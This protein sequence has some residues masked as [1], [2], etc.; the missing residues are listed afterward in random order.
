MQPIETPA[1]DPISGNKLARNIKHLTFCRASLA[2]VSGLAAGILGL[3]SLAGFA[4]YLGVSAVLSIGL[5]FKTGFNVQKYF[6]DTLTMLTFGI[7]ANMPS[8]VLFW[9]LAYGIVHIYD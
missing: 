3:E 9:T 6:P 7:F 5:M 4:F 2:I 1:R 8:Y